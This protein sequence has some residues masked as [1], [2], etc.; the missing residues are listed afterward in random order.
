MWLLPEADDVADDCYRAMQAGYGYPN[1]G[2][3][4]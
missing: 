3:M 1:S 2:K 4:N